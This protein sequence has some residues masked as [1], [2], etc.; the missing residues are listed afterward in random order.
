[1]DHEV[2]TTSIGVPGGPH[3]SRL[4]GSEKS[5]LCSSPRVHSQLSGLLSLPR[6]FSGEP[7]SIVRFFSS[8]LS[9]WVSAGNRSPQPQEEWQRTPET[10]FA[11]LP[12]VSK[13]GNRH[14][15]KPAMQG[16]KA[17]ATWY[18]SSHLLKVSGEEESVTATETVHFTERFWANPTCRY[19]SEVL[20]FTCTT[21][22]LKI[23]HAWWKFLLR[24]YCSPKRLN[25]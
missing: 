18:W 15:S 4:T 16:V 2:G 11:P 14:K 17:T 10:F 7:G 8:C 5:V 23:R 19:R 21:E 9:R 25:I 20:N 22:E 13:G 12:W 3:N 24:R 1:M 6:Y